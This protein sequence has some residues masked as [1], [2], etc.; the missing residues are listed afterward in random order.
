[1]APGLTAV[2]S[3]RP[4]PTPLLQFFSYLTPKE[5]IEVQIELSTGHK[6]KYQPPAQQTCSSTSS[7][8][9]P[10]SEKQSNPNLVGNSTY[11]LAQ[12]AF[13]RSGD[14]GDTCN[15]GV[16]A[17]TPEIYPALKAHLTA[18]VV[19]EYFQHK[20]QPGSKPGLCQRYELPGVHG[21]NFVLKNSLGGGGIA[22]LTPDPQGKGYAQQLAD[23]TLKNL[24]K[25]L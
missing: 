13:L 1:M 3:G 11:S 25:L 16:I 4:K 18:S 14:K 24:P 19:E 12:L 7:V 10:E 15:I 20:F 8:E 17:R 2:V 23:F 21:L 6:E 9:N 5:S 22:S